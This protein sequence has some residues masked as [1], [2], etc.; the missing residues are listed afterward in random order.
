[1]K[2]VGMDPSL[3]NFGVVEAILNLDNMS[4]EVQAMRV[5]QTEPEKDK[6]V[7]KQVR[8]NS[9]DLERARA[10]YRGAMEAVEGRFLAFIEVPVGSQSA[11]AMASHGICLGVIAAVAET[12]PVIQVTPNEVKLAGCGIKTATKTE[13]IE[14]MIAKHPNAPWPMQKKGGVM[15]PIASQ[16]EHLADAVA[17]I[18]AGLAS[19]EFRQTMAVLKAT[20]M[21]KLAMARSA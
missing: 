14:A 10:L 17:A 6:K 19:D 12:L 2:I 13:M 16:C 5:V 21:F 1:M 9:Q 3:S 20:P 7:R 4:I 18:E 8:M 15:I 11:R